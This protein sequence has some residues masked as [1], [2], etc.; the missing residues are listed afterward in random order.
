M[1]ASILSMAGFIEDV[2]KSFDEVAR[3]GVTL[4]RIRYPS[5][6]LGASMMLKIA[7]DSVTLREIAKPGPAGRRFWVKIRH[8]HGV[9]SLSMET[10]ECGGVVRNLAA[11]DG[12][13]TNH[14]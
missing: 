4:F 11:P 13:R 6:Q 10:N 2:M 5:A 14:H 1:P 3:E 7:G 12:T 8:A 9:E